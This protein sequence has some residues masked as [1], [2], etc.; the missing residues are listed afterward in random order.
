DQSIAPLVARDSFAVVNTTGSASVREALVLPG[1]TIDRPRVVE[2]CMLGIGSVGLMSVEGPAAN[3]SATDLIC[4]AYRLIH[5]DPTLR[6]EVFN[7]K[8]EAIAIGQGC[9]A[10]TMPLSDGRLSSFAAPMSEHIR[11]LQRDGL[12][13]TGEVLVG[14]LA[15][16]GLNQ[17]WH[18]KDIRPRIV[19]GDGTDSVVRLSPEVDDTIRREVAAR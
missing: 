15:A 12:P 2:A 11:R 13:E 19:V 6:N 7:T 9:A 5:S 18:R 14:S 8:A 3:P 17:I 16:D 1:V 4:E 10:I